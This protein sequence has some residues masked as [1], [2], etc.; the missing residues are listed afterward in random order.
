MPWPTPEVE[1]PLPRGG[2]HITAEI[3]WVAGLEGLDILRAQ[4]QAFRELLDALPE[5]G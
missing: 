2:L 3:N 4:G 5:A 1:A